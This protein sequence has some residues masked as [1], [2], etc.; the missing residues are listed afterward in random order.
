VT[1]TVP[2]PPRVMPMTPLLALCEQRLREAV[3]GHAAEVGAPAA[4]T[5]AAGGK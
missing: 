5:L 3:S 2:L 4:D 1:S